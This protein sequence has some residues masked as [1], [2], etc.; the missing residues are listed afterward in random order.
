MHV[1][2]FQNLIEKAPPCPVFVIDA[3]NVKERYCHC[4][5]SYTFRNSSKSALS[6]SLCVSARPWG[7]PG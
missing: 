7:A 6:W 2:L 5:L 1:Q 4:E 3:D